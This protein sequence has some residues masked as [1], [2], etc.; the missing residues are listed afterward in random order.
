MRFDG[1]QKLPRYP[2]GQPMFSCLKCGSTFIYTWEECGAD[3]GDG[4]TTSLEV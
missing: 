1:I 3:G 2:E 4:Y